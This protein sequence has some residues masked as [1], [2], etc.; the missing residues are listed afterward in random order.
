MKIC[1]N[2]LAI[3]NFCSVT[4]KH[5]ELEAFLVLHSICFLVG[6][7][8]HLHQ[9]ITNSEVFPKDYHATGKTE[10]VMVEECSY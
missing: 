8:S 2:N 4:N 7:E 5:A 1:Y 3:I 9:E 6:T 10:T